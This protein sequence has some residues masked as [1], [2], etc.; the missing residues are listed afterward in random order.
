MTDPTANEDLT[1]YPSL[2]SVADVIELNGSVTL[3]VDQ[4]GLTLTGGGSYS[5]VDTATAIEGAVRM[6]RLGLL[7]LLSRALKVLDTSLQ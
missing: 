5:V 3:T 1:T 7:P 2:A 6:S 4:A